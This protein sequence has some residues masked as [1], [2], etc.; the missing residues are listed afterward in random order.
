MKMKGSD[1]GSEAQLILSDLRASR[2]QVFAELAGL[3]EERL[4][5]PA[6]WGGREFDARFILL[7][8]ADHEE[9]HA[10]QV[11]KTLDGFGWRQT[12]AQQILGAA[13]V[14]RGD[15]YGALLGLTDAD[16]DLAP[17]GEWPL[18]LTLWHIAQSERT[19][20]A[21]TGWAAEL[22]RAGREW[23]PNERPEQIA[24]DGD[25]ATFIG[26]LDKE[27]EELL[28]QLTGIEDEA[29]TAPTVWAE[30]RV[31]VRFR[32]MR[33]AHHEREHTAHILKW[34]GQVGRPLTDPQR[35]LANAW[36]ARGVLEGHL[37]G[38]P[39]DLLDREPA[40]GDATIRAL[41]AH[42]QRTENILKGRA[43]G[44]A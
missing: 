13:Q 28:E 6:P 40:N 38:L 16:L 31:D 5:V 9:E 8:Y 11:R 20:R 32:L 15:L 43:L 35:L 27:R 7:R 42:V 1:M 4:N 36:R 34:R 3:P 26:H 14:T 18:R 44:Q 41:L 21:A 17:A 39:D 2:R 25:F 10:L 24:E 33:V 29:M 22:H 37:V 19:Y 30:I 23:E 12:E